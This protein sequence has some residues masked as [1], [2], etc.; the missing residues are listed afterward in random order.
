MK[1]GH[2]FVDLKG[3]TKRTKRSGSH[4]MADFLKN[5]FYVPI[6]AAAKRYH[7]KIGGEPL[8]GHRAQ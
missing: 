6:L 5:E 1:E 8:A 3:F 7:L 2:L 4:V